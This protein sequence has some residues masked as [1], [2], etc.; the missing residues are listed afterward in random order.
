[1]AN[2][3]ERARGQRCQVRLPGI[4][5]TYETVVLAHYRM[6]GISGMGIKPPDVLA[7]YSCGPCHAY[8][9]THKD[10]ET[11]LAFAQA[12]MRTINLLVQGKVLKW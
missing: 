8:V 1:M 3:R 7:A 2:L 6:A 11:Q 4:C 10:A 12:V 9:D 5:G